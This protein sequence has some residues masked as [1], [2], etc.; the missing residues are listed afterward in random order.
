M[1]TLLHINY[2]PIMQRRRS[3]IL[4]ILIEL[5]P[6][7]TM[8]FF[9]SASRIELLLWL[10]KIVISLITLP[11][12]HV[13][14][15]PILSKPTASLFRLRKV[16][17]GTLKPTNCPALFTSCFRQRSFN[18]RNP[19]FFAFG[20]ATGATILITPLF[21]VFRITSIPDPSLFLSDVLRAYK[22]IKNTYTA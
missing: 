17:C 10:T 6:V 20:H 22:K 9:S 8:T 19:S 12:L 7:N 11:S 13:G 5:P 16:V 21:G 14:T 15:P 18:V 4:S 1:I 2:E 3:I